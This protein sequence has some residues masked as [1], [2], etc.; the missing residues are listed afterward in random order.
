M[1]RLGRFGAA[2]V[3]A[4]AAFCPAQAAD[5]A[6]DGLR[7][8][9]IGNSHTHSI[10]NVLMPLAHAA[11]HTNHYYSWSSILGAP[12]RW[13]RDHDD[14]S[15]GWEAEPWSTGLAP[16]RK[17]DALTLQTYATDD[18]EID[19]AVMFSGLAWKGN[20]RCRVYLYTIWPGAS[21]DWDNPPAGRTEAITEK[22]AAA[23]AKAFPDAPPP[24]VM[25]TSLVIRE[26]G[27]LADHGRLPHVR[28]RFAL[29]SDGGH[30]G[31]FGNYAVNITVCS[32][33]YD[34]PPFAYPSR[35]GGFRTQQRTEKVVDLDKVQYEIPAETAAVIQRVVWDVLA[36]YPPARMNVGLVVADRSLPPAIAGRAYR[37]PFK[38]LNASG[39]A[40]WSLAGGAL[41]KG[42]ALSADGLL[43][44]TPAEAGQSSLTVRVADGAGRF[45]KPFV[46][47]VSE[48]RPPVV[49]AQLL[50]AVPLDRHVFS[51][52]T[53]TGG[54]GHVTWTL[55]DGTL[56]HGVTLTLPGILVGTPGVA[57]EYRFTV[58]A[59]DAHPDGPRSA[60]RA[61]QWTIG[62]ASPEALLVPKTYEPV[63]LDGKLDESFWKLD[64]P[65]AKAAEGE[66]AKKASFAA[67]W[68]D[69][70]DGRKGAVCIY[71]AVKVADG[72]A[73]KTPTDGV[74]LFLD[75]LHNREAVYNADD[76][77]FRIDRD[78]RKRSVRGKP[79]W[80][81][82]VAAA[83][84]PGGYVVEVAIPRNYL[85]GEGSWV[86]VE[87]GTVYGFD[88]AVTEGGTQPARR[89]WRGSARN[90]EDTRGF[91]SIVLT[92]TLVG[93]AAPEKR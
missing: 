5:P 62:P 76:M 30:L 33:L 4:I 34:E 86:G 3:L 55:A 80:F 25:P 41:P 6:A 91:G 60:Q 1:Q 83:E 11:G 35:I 88:L 28:N 78:G 10:R 48:D 64:Q 93:K 14:Q 27:R 44:G 46:L 82:K 73:G 38:A 50:P 37:H 89:V 32:M 47:T 17:W 18:K 26:L 57:G 29:L 19:A 61:F 31:D 77:H 59:T 7:V 8:Y 79:D 85:V 70:A 69:R 9:H 87:A 24:R 52:L 21:E 81:L 68:T 49:E 56:P 66:P 20:P 2:G 13:I 39:A 72:P 40:R 92:D 12:L 71:L 75:A 45:D 67:V 15:G 54:V 74:E 84:A 51:P 22:C 53:V 58:R 63:T 36:T 65:L 16:G 42:L 23:I 43:A 90:A